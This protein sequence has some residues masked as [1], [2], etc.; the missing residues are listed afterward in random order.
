[1]TSAVTPGYPEWTVDEVHRSLGKIRLVDVR[2]PDEYVGELGHIDGAE[3]VPVAG[4]ESASAGW[5]KHEKVVL[6]CRSGARSG[7]AAALLAAKGFAEPINMA[8]GMI[9][10]NGRGLPVVR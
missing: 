1:M 7:R 6:V 2:E 5:S 3:L 8:G 9:A 4:V 10:W